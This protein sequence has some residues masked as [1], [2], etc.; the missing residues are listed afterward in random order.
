MGELHE[1][2]STGEL[3]ALEECLKRG[4]DPSEPGPE[5]G[6]KAPLHIACSNGYKKCVYVLLKAGADANS[7][8]DAGWT[9]AHC[10]C[11][12]GQVRYTCRGQP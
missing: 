8:T 2:A 9:P 4:L 10:A 1:A 11:E 5:W 7:R 12:R 6:G 3:E